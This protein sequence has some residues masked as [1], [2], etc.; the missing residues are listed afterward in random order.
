VG[1]SGPNVGRALLSGAGLVYL[2]AALLYDPRLIALFTPGELAPLTLEKLRA[3]RID[4]AA[5]AAVLLALSFVVARVPSLSRWLARDRVASLL[6]AAVALALPLTLLDCGLRPFV[7]PKSTLYTADRELGWK[8]V[9]GAE[10]EDG[11]ARVRIN[12]KGLRGPEVAYERA[13]GAVRI[14]WLGDSV[15]FGYGVEATDA[16]FPFRVASLLAERLARPVESVDA[17]VGGYSPWQEQA[18]LE[19]DG[20]R[21]APD[22]VVVGFVLNDLTEP[23]SLVRYG[24]KG[25]GWQLARSARGALDRWLSESALAV[26]LRDGFAT[27]RFGRDVRRGAQAVESHD[28]QRMIAQPQDPLWQQSWR[29]AE[30]N[31][32]RIFASARQRGVSAALVIF[33]YAFQLDAPEATAGPQRRLAAFARE[34][35]VPVLDLLPVLA[36]SREQALF[37]DASHLSGSGHEVAADS[38]AAFLL[39]HRSLDTARAPRA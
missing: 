28:V 22:L 8:L 32:A 33:P 30:G 4:F 21:Y 3:V 14:L 20:W 17:G 36:A 13:E 19:R 34:Q 11:G 24:G 18:W 1:S 39:E 5:A 10:D 7:E 37:L 29:I 6:L 35:G 23:L 31:L 25:E 9:P 12:A 38:I 15:T 26:S 16:I 2:A 27:L